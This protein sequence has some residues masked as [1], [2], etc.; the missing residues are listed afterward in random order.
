MNAKHF[1]M[2]TLLN[3]LE[4]LVRKWRTLGLVSSVEGFQELISNWASGQGI[5]SLDSQGARRPYEEVRMD[6][7]KIL[8]NDIVQS[9]IKIEEEILE[10]SNSANEAFEQLKAAFE[11]LEQSWL[12]PECNLINQSVSELKKEFD[13]LQLSG[14][15]GKRQRL[16][17]QPNIASRVKEI[18][19]KVEL[20]YS[21]FSS[22]PSTETSKILREPKLACE[23]LLDKVRHAIIQIREYHPAV[24]GVSEHKVSTTKRR[25]R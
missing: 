14:N 24:E 21:R 13:E 1:L 4:V 6:F 20:L 15:S 17:S 8:P 7:L 11:Q 5:S 10:L 9:I 19:A 22:L 25:R 23:Q 12:L 18:G 16:L 2:V 3:D